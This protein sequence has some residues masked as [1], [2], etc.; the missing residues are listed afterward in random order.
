MPNRNKEPFLAE[1]ISS[2]L[3]QTFADFELVVV[4][5]ASTDRS[6]SLVTES[7]K[8]DP[9]IRLIEH[10]SHRGPASARNTAIREARGEFVFLLDSDDVFSPTWIE[11]AMRRFRSVTG[12]WVAYADWWVMNERGDRLARKRSHTTS[13]GAMFGEFLSMSLQVNSVLAAPRSCFIE[14]GMYDESVEWGE[15]Y[16]LVLR[17]SQRF[18]FA[19]V[20]E[21]VYGYRLHP[22]NSWR[23]LSKQELYRHKAKVL[24]KHVGEGNGWLTPKRMSEVEGRLAMYYRISGQWGALVRLLLRQKVMPYLRAPLIFPLTNAKRSSVLPVP[25]PLNT[26]PTAREK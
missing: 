21:E 26:S 23:R 7:G 20:D 3:S 8:N 16:D 1:A 5:D 13:S 12:R 6:A 22:G 2:V 19:Y 17:M 15:D 14:A 25:G 10:A 24:G 4:D 9:R 11:H 18:P